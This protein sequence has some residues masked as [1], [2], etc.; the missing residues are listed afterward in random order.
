MYADMET[1]CQ[2]YHV[3]H[4][5]R[6]ESVLCG[7]GTVFNQAIL[8]C[9]YWHSVECDETPNHYAVNEELGRVLS[10]IYRFVC[11]LI[12]LLFKIS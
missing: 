11:D 8:A 4:N 2:A 7:T 3:C 6:K 12:K 9:D 1:Q 10:S 5:G